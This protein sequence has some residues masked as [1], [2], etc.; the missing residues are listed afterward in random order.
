MNE[1]AYAHEGECPRCE[2]TDIEREVIY[3]TTHR[4]VGGVVFFCNTCGLHT[5]VLSSDR[6]AWFDAHR[7]WRSP[8]VQDETYEEF[9][10]RW[11]K[12]VGSAGYGD[13]EPLGPILPP[14]NGQ[15]PPPAPD[16]AGDE[17]R[18]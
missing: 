7:S 5:K 8:A 10:K 16:D 18:K 1:T 6:E 11:K 12:R 4:E 3:L 14:V 9:A 2:S 17:E 15:S 13:P